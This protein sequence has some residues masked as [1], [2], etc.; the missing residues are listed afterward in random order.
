VGKVSVNVNIE[1]AV[2]PDTRT[3]R[4]IEMDC[5]A[6]CR[7]QSVQ[8]CFTSA[9][10]LVLE[11]IPVHAELDELKQQI[12]DLRKAR[13]THSNAIGLLED[14]MGTAPLPDEHVN[15]KADKAMRAKCKKEHAV[16]VGHVQKID[17]DLAEKLAR[18]A[19]LHERTK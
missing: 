15:A 9:I 8:K 13:E 7:E 4:L 18:R 14:A 2:G 16:H 1:N 6:D 17:G 19:E 10:S 5:C 3:G 12:H 11:A